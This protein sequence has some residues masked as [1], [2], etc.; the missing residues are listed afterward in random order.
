[1]NQMKGSMME[2]YAYH[3][4]YVSIDEID[5]NEC[6]Q[7]NEIFNES[8]NCNTYALINPNVDLPLI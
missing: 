4:G 8:L 7:W 3:N 2:D 5:I 1:M 6:D